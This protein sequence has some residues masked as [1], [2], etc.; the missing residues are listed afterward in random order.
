MTLLQQYGTV[1]Y[2]MVLYGSWSHSSCGFLMDDNR[3][4]CVFCCCL[5]GS[6]ISVSSSFWSVAFV[7]G[8]MDRRNYGTFSSAMR[9]DISFLSFLAA[10]RSEYLC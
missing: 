9:L 5:L 10:P 4:E 1:W 2:G 8:Y 7:R 6:V 3:Y